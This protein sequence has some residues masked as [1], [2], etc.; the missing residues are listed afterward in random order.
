MTGGRDRPKPVGGDVGLI[1]PP[2]IDQDEPSRPGLRAKLV[3]PAGRS[4]LTRQAWP[5]P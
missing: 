2:A 3:R 1:I 4:S 5:A